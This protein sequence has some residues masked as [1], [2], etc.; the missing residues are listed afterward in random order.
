MNKSSLTPEEIFGFPGGSSVWKIVPSRVNSRLD[1]ASSTCC[2]KASSDPERSV[3]EFH[4][5]I[6]APTSERTDET[7]L[8]RLG[9]G[10]RRIRW[11]RVQQASR[12]DPPACV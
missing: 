12:R 11:Q 8:S 7:E 4:A 3:Y 9:E 10:C 6:A 2:S 5:S 1:S